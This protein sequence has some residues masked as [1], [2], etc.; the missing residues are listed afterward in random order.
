MT[1]SQEKCSRTVQKLLKKREVAQLAA[2]AR[3]DEIQLA[4]KLNAAINQ[5]YL[6][7][8]GK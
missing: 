2:G 4:M 8:D 5:L 3:A 1:H 6:E 7:L